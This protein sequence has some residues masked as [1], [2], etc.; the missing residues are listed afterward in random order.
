VLKKNDFT[1]RAKIKEGAAVGIDFGFYRWPDVPM[2]KSG[3]CSADA[4][5]TVEFFGVGFDCRRQGFGIIGG[6][7]GNGS[8]YVRNINDLICDDADREQVS[9]MLRSAKQAQINRAVSDLVTL[10]KE[11]H[12]LR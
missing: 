4:E 1:F 6:D 12:E 5:F 10:E 7:Y 8:V 9:A 2:P 11:I 3:R